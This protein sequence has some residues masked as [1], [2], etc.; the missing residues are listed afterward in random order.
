[1][2]DGFPKTWNQFEILKKKGII[3]HKIINLKIDRRTW[4]EKFTAPQNDETFDF[5]IFEKE[6]QNF[7]ENCN[8]YVKYMFVN[9]EASVSN[10]I[11]SMNMLNLLRDH[12][13]RKQNFNQLVSDELPAYC[14]DVGIECESFQQMTNENFKLYCPVS[15]TLKKDIILC[16][17]DRYCVL[18]KVLFEII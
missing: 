15:C 10:A 12:V 5:N 1:M 14:Y 11:N 16:E 18:H 3:P 8:R 7:E 4:S 6:I 13:D 2:V 17:T 9:M